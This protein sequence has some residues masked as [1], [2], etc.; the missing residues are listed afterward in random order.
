MFAKGRGTVDCERVSCLSVSTMLGETA[1]EAVKPQIL[2][3][4]HIYVGLFY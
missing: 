2:H 4:W 1:G 3:E